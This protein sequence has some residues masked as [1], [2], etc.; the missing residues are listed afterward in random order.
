MQDASYAR[1]SRRDSGRYPSPFR[2]I[3]V[4]MW[5]CSA[6][7]SSVALVTILVF[8]PGVILRGN[9]A[10]LSARA[11]DRYAD[12]SSRRL[13]PSHGLSAMG[14]AA[15]AITCNP[16]HNLRSFLTKHTASRA[17]QPAVPHKQTSMVFRSSLFGEAIF[18]GICWGQLVA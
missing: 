11:G 14:S 12:S 16:G 9:I 3:L 7:P 1:K 2:M 5:S 13:S 4:I 10:V 15:A 8:G 18:A 6:F 17:G